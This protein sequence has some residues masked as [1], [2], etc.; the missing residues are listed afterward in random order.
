MNKLAI[1][2]KNNNYTVNRNTEYAD[3][4][5]KFLDIYEDMNKVENINNK[6]LYSK[7][8]EA[9]SDI[10]SSLIENYDNF[11][12]FIEE[13][14]DKFISENG[15]IK[16][17]RLEKYYNLK[18]SVGKSNQQVKGVK[19]KTIS[20]N[21]MKNMNKIILD[22][23]KEIKINFIKNIISTI[24]KL[25]TEKPKLTNNISSF[26]KITEDRKDDLILYFKNNNNLIHED[27]FNN[28]S[29]Y[30]GFNNYKGRNQNFI[31]LFNYIYKYDKDINLLI[32]IDNENSILYERNIKTL[33]NFVFLHLLFKITQY[34]DE[35]D[36]SEDSK[37]E[38]CSRL[39][40]DIMQ[41]IVE[42]YYDVL[43]IHENRNMEQFNKELSKQKKKNNFY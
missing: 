3:N 20:K 7:L 8:L 31:D 36:D 17:R 42:E 23:N 40:I 15:E 25:N 11:S 24:G 27:V 2:I 43:Y 14:L 32:G 29:G 6:Q 35:L 37:I 26:W 13:R 12:K 4:F 5:L 19:S 33:I 38:D 30:E 1:F 18:I 28:T 21:I 16:I 39:F 22:D 10:S 41:N 9:I 34:V